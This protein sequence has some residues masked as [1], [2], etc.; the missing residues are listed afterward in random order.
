MRWLYT[1]LLSVLMPPVVL[2]LLWR[3]RAQPAYRQRIGERFGRVAAPVQPV[4]I[5]VHAVSVGEALAAIP[6]IRALVA[7]HGTGRVLVTTTTP[8]G[9]ERVR[10]LFGDTVLHVYAPYDLPWLLERFLGCMRPQCVVV[11]ETELWPNL[12]R[13]L[14]QRGVPLILANARLSPASYR[15]YRRLRRFA[16]RTLGHCSLI[17]AQSAAD[18]ERF[19]RLGAPPQRLQV[20]G[21]LKFDQPLPM[22]QVDA[23]RALRERLGPTRPVWIAASTHDGEELCA[24]AAHRAVLRLRPDALLI[25]V[26]RH[27]QRFDAAAR[28]IGDQGFAYLRRSAAATDVGLD[29]APQVLL[30]DSMGEMFVYYAAADVAFVGGSLRPAGGHNVLEPA[31]I[32]MPV[33]FGPHMD[34]FGPARDLLLAAEGAIQVDAETLA[35]TLAALLGDAPR[36]TRM[37]TAARGVI[38]ANR[39]ACARLLALIEALPSAES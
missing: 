10:A 32:G 24:L 12:F 34:N 27:P 13:A 33:L 18:A 9:S 26:P 28:L 15:G 3:S 19:R 31:A 8:T 39:G 6:L 35:A 5:W 37:A 21:N 7:R 30:G 11:M 22:D 38:D 36:R 23:G 17:A 1:V 20:V 4:A 14:A 2:R 29:G 16:A 25:L